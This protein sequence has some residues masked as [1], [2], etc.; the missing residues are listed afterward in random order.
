M[1]VPVAASYSGSTPAE[2]STADTGWKEFFFGGMTGTGKEVDGKLFIIS[3]EVED[4]ISKHG[5]S[6]YAEVFS[7]NF[8]IGE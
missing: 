6:F 8:I 2:A 1:W 3:G 4:N 7:Y 5:C